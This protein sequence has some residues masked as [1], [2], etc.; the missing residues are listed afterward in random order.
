MAFAFTYVVAASAQR[1]IR[2]LRTSGRSDRAIASTSG[3]SGMIVYGVGV[4]TSRCTRAF[5]H[6][7]SLNAEG[8][9]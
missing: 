1:R 7:A 6:A 4:R 3:S 5:S 2:L 9:P 8:N